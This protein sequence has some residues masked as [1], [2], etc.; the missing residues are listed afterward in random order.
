MDRRFISVAPIGYG[1]GIVPSPR[2]I[3]DIVH[4]CWN[5][6]A[7]I[8]HLHPVDRNGNITSDISLFEQTVDLIKQRC[9]III[10]GSTGG[11]SSLSM[12]DRS[13]SIGVRNVEQ[14]SLNMGSTNL[15]GSVFE[16]SEDDIRY[17]A[18]KMLEN[19]VKAELEIFNEPMI[20]FT[21][22]IRN[23]GLLLDPLLFQLFILEKEGTDAS[24]RKIGKLSQK[25]MRLFSELQSIPTDSEVSLT[26]HGRKDFFPIALGISLGMNIRVGFEDSKHISP[27]RVAKDNAEIVA[28]VAKIMKSFG[29]E[30][31]SPNETR[32]LLNMKSRRS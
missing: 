29:L 12:A 16:N 11:V 24:E 32:G 31:A 8:V 4:R 2:E 14:G 15:F 25:Q 26:V 1:D 23:E 3:A 30:P 10:Q 13:L 17:V 22:E 6:G 20:D 27:T 7:A 18:R 19:G 9:D 21:L 28:E 5:A